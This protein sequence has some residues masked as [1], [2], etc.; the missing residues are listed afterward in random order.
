MFKARRYPAWRKLYILSWL[1]SLQELFYRLAGSL[2]VHLFRNTCFVYKHRDHLGTFA[3]L[4]G[5]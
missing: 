2:M 1:G 4:K 5:A 3:R